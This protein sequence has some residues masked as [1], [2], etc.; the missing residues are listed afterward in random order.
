MCKK[1]NTVATDLGNVTIASHTD[2]ATDKTSTDEIIK[3]DSTLDEVAKKD[4]NTNWI[5]SNNVEEVDKEDDDIEYNEDKPTVSNVHKGAPKVVVASMS[6][7]CPRLQE[8]CS[9][10]PETLET[11]SNYERLLHR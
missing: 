10:A 9:R 2:D 7:G 4:I 8:G 11:D 5:S 6:K 1:P 3:K